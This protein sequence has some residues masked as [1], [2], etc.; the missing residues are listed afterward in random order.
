MEELKMKIIYKEP[1]KEIEGLSLADGKIIVK[2]TS[3]LR[4]VIIKF[5]YGKIKGSITVLFL[6]EEGNEIAERIEMK[7]NEK[8]ILYKT[9]V[10]LPLTQSNI[11]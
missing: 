1:D 5:L 3:G 7:D 10:K 4:D 8:G 2:L 9:M 11:I 6:D